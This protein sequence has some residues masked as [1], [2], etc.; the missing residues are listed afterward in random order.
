MAVRVWGN[1]RERGVTVK[2]YG[3]SFSDGGTL[4]EFVAMIAQLSVH[5]KNH[6]IAYLKKI[7]KGRDAE[8][9]KKFKH[10]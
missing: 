2:G 4:L 7:Y 6:R 8:N 5:P 9:M 3:R 10:I 1:R